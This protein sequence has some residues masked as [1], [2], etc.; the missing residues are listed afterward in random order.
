MDETQRKD[1]LLAAL[2]PDVPFDGWSLAAMRAAAQ[3]VGMDAV[4]LAT[5]FPRG[6]R[7]A[8]AWFSDWADRLT[9]E[10]MAARPV[11]GMKLAD[12][13]ALGVHTRLALL[14]PHREAARRGMSLLALP[15]NAALGMSLLFHTVD[16]LWHAA[17]DRSTDFSYYTKRA[18]L[19][20]IYAATML[21]WFDDRS[22]E[23][24]ATD[25]FLK[26][27]LDD[28]MALPRLRAELERLAGHLPNPRRFF[29]AARPRP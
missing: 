17:D 13:I 21:Y 10:T 12:R 5:L 29:R 2:L 18:M 7:D 25:A 15:G 27:R 23:C 20:G 8:V 11:D 6:P 3:R 24:A 22:D 26:R 19:A 4:E 1:A 14:A 28:A 9:L 16:A